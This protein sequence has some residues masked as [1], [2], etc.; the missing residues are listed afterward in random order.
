MTAP[1]LAATVARW[2]H[3]SGL[4]VAGGAAVGP[5]LA[6]G[7]PH[8][9]AQRFG[10][11]TRGWARAGSSLI[12]VGLLATLAAQAILFRDPFDPFWPQV[13]GLVNRTDW[14]RAW[15]FQAALALGLVALA[16]S[17]RTHGRAFAGLAAAAAGALAF[18]GH[19]WAVEEWRVLTLAAEGV[20]AVAAAAWLGGVAYLALT[21]RG[22]SGPGAYRAT[23]RFSGLAVWA[24]PALVGTG[25]WATVAHAGGVGAVVEAASGSGWAR[26]LVVKTGLFLFMGALGAYNWRVAL[27]RLRRAEEAGGGGDGGFA[28]GPAAWEAVT[29]LAVLGA[30]ALLVGLTPP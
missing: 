8:A 13:A 3:L 16:W 10:Q 2:V 26:T 5:Y 14:G 27:P 18:T 17:P 29:G 30:T 28:R 11:A 1:E 21:L 12:A 22:G 19:S 6:S 15:S 24:V 23:A 7:A 25:L 4:A 20:H 9:L